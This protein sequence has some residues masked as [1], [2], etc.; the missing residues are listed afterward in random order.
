[1]EPAE[2]RHYPYMQALDVG[3]YDI[4]LK[5]IVKILLSGTSDLTEAEF[6]L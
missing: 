6:E 2:K 1:M 3:E 5:N 4:R